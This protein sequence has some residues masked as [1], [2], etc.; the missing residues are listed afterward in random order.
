M[1]TKPQDT[2]LM[3]WIEATVPDEH[4]ACARKLL[5]H[6]DAGGAEPSWT[7]RARNSFVNFCWGADLESESIWLRT[8]R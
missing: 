3:D 8:H 4:E 6:L 7:K 2:L 1:G 5:A